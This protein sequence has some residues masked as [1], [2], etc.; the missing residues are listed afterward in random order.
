MKIFVSWSGETSHQVAVRLR[1][2]LPKVLPNVAPWVS[3]EDISK[4][5]RW[6]PEV[7]RI[8]QECNAGIVC[9]VP[10]NVSEPW[11]NFEA[12]AISKVV[13]TARVFPFLVGL[14]IREMRGPLLQF[15]CTEFSLSEVKKMVHSI[16]NLLVGSAS[17]SHGIYGAVDAHWS[18]LERELDTIAIRSAH[19]RPPQQAATA[20]AAPKDTLD[21]AS[22]GAPELKLLHVKFLLAMGKDKYGS[23]AK[24]ELADQF[25]LSEREVTLYLRWLTERG[26]V[27]QTQKEDIFNVEKFALDGKGWDLLL[28][29]C[30][31][32]A[33]KG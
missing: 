20:K 33:P 13:D 9:V 18:S 17:V 14:S 24:W 8:L 1:D 25:N 4:G 30:L 26:Y 6:S 32:P 19:Q 28:A 7:A 10:E 5:S 31:V 23:P 3:S 11:L 2:W 12:G 15:Q 21:P 29:N 27:K 22:L 16:S